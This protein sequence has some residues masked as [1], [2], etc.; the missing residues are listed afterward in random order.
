MNSATVR[1]NTRR[2]LRLR[3][4]SYGLPLSVL[5]ALLGALALG[6]L[7]SMGYG[8]LLIALVALIGL[9]VWVRPRP[10]A[11]S[12]ILVGVAILP[13]PAM[14]GARIHGIPPTTALGLITV[15]A[16]LILW[17]H[18][19]ARGAA[20]HMSVYALISLLVLVTASIIQLGLSP[21]AHVN[22]IYQV[23]LFWFAGLALGTILA[24]DL[25]MT[26]GIG[27]LALPL[28]GLALVESI[29]GRPNLWSELIGANGYDRVGVLGGSVRAASTF[30][31][32]LVAGTALAVMAFIAIAQPGGYR[33]NLVFSL[34]VVGAVVTISRSALVGLAVG[35]LIYFASKHSQRT[36]IVGAVI[37][38]AVFGWLLYTYIPQIHTSFDSRVVTAN[39]QGQGIRLNSLHSLKD[40]F[41]TGRRELLVGRGLGGSTAYLSLTGGNLGFGV[42]DN[43]YVTSFYDSGMLVV[44]AAILL[45]I[46]GLARA[47]PHARLLAPLAV[48]AATMFFFEALYWPVTGLLFW[49]TLGF[50]TARGSATTEPPPLTL[51]KPVNQ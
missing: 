41:L 23:S 1:T 19:Q 18:R 44:L 11:L 38:T 8:L 2:T 42:Y 34:I 13:T 35:L 24:S 33:R 29:V 30:G 37:V 46:V 9:V 10:Y 43:Q 14:G 48:S 36:Q 49:M 32:P 12:A 25:R 27:L 7:V 5:A 39:V 4:R 47:R 26:S 15:C 50:A 3:P 20:L 17:W 31:H 16:T 21:Y 28:A 22:A 51:D 40:D 6:V 45:M